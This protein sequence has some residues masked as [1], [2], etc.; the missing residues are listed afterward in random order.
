MACGGLGRAPCLRSLRPTLG[1][2]RAPRGPAMCCGATGPWRG[3]PWEPDGLPL[4]CRRER[5]HS[6][7]GG[8]VAQSADPLTGYGKTSIMPAEKPTELV[9]I[10]SS[11]EDLK[12]FPDD[13]QDVIG[14]ALHLAQMGGKHPR[15][16]PLRGDA[17]FGAV[18]SWRSSTT[19]M[20]TPTAPCTRSAITTSCTCCTASRRRRSTASPHPSQTLSGSSGASR[21]PML[22][23]GADRE[24]SHDHRG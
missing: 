20:A 4:C 2:D 23:T 3:K 14:Y 8:V 24:A 11:L 18:A 16:K 15:A 22:T 1:P 13:V 5:S 7:A 10:G 21:S 17:A 6:A 9:W 19:T 12:T